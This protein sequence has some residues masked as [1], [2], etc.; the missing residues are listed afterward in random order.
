MSSFN[1]NLSIYMINVDLRNRL[2]K[3]KVFEVKLDTEGQ[4]FLADSKWKLSYT[5]TCQY[6]IS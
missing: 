6:A 2:R 3:D 1:V 4:I 5:A